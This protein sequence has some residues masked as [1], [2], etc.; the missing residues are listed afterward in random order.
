[1]PN[2]LLLVLMLRSRVVESNS[3]LSFNL[4]RED[5]KLTCNL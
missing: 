1:M 3:S 4:Y 5:Y 2:L